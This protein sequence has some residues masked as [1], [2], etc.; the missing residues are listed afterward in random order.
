MKNKLII[1]AI[2]LILV[3]LNSSRAQTLAEIRPLVASN[4]SGYFSSPSYMTD[5]NPNTLW[6]SGGGASQWIDI[7]VGYDRVVSKIQLLTAQYPFGV[8]QHNIYGRTNAGQWVYFGMLNGYTTDSQWLTFNINQSTPIRYIVVM[9]SASPSWVAWREIKVFDGLKPRQVGDVVG[10][11]LAASVIGPAGHIG[12]WTGSEVLEILN[13]PVVVQN[14]SY[15][16]FV[17]RVTPDKVW[18]PV[19]TNIPNFT[20]KSCFSATCNWQSGTSDRTNMTTRQA[21]LNRA[22]QIRTIG[23]SYT[24][25]AFPTTAK[26]RKLD[27]YTGAY[28]PAVRGVYRCDTFILDLFSMTKSSLSSELDGTSVSPERLISGDNLTWVTNMN[29][30]LYWTTREGLQKS[31]N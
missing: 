25:T 8:T 24:L 27:L 10:R 17:S 1:C 4:A 31:P 12:F 6:N 22:N 5:N 28:T 16:N 30:L 13:E 19:Y 14:N 26:P 7:D 20:I 23:A 2:G 21:M 18:D 29:Y 3:I 11:D 9:T 15:V